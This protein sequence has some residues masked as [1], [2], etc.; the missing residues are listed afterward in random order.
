MSLTVTLIVPP[1]GTLYPPRSAQALVS[2]AWLT[3]TSRPY[4]PLGPETA[5]AYP[6]WGLLA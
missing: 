4:P 1:A 6:A 2:A 3:R 5:T